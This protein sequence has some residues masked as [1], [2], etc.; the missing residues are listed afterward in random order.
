MRAV[1]GILVLVLVAGAGCAAAPENTS[2]DAGARG[3]DAG[4]GSG[5]FTFEISVGGNT[6]SIFGTQVSI[7]SGEATAL[8]YKP[9]DNDPWRGAPGAAV[10]DTSAQAGTG[11][12]SAHFEMK[13][14]GRKI[15][16]ITKTEASSGASG[17]TDAKAGLATFRIDASATGLKKLRLK[18]TCTGTVSASNV[19][20]NSVIV[21]R[22]S[23][24]NTAYCNNSTFPTSPHDLTGGVAE[25]NADAEGVAYVEVSP[26]V[27]VV[28][29]PDETLGPSTGKAEATFTFEVEPVY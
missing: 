12:G 22:S 4:S 9:D 26:S 16:L 18:L 14:D 5:A 24:G 20:A 17:S 27:E 28:A 3:A 29:A 10:F 2:P 8:T 15:T 23:D 1:T 7:V 13:V 21:L 6:T 25:E 11:T 19:G